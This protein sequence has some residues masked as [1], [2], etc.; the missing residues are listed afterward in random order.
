MFNDSHH[1][2]PFDQ[3]IDDFVKDGDGLRSCSFARDDRRI[4]RESRSN[5]DVHMPYTLV[6]PSKL[7]DLLEA[8]AIFYEI[9]YCKHRYPVF[10]NE[11]F[12]Q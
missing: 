6:V 4:R 1:F 11:P 9:I 12:A 2:F 8:V 5:S 3:A 7:Q 10:C